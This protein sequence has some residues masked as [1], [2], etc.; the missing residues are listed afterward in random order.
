MPF[1]N[2]QQR[3]FENRIAQLIARDWQR[4]LQYTWF[5]QR[6][7]FARLT[8]KEHDCDVIIGVPSNYEPAATTRP[9]YRSSYLFVSRTDRHLDIRSFD[10][11][12]L[13]H[14]KIGVQIIGND[15]VNSPPAHAL[16]ARGIIDNIAGYPIYDA[17]KDIVSAVARGDVDLAVVWGP[18]AAWSARSQRVALDLVPVSPQIDLPFLPFVFD[19]SMGVRR[20]DTAL[21][22]QLDQEIERRQVEIQKILDEYGVPRV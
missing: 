19:I 12:R 6:R 4:P 13:H 9:Y 3:G 7:G 21:R 8:L 11:P 14:L 10:D 16:A 17:Q 2:M 15:H 20:G 1:S 18:Q 22:E 5:P